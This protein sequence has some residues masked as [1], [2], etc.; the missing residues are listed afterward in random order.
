MKQLS[1]VII[2]LSCLSLTCAY[3][4]EG[5]PIGDH[6]VKNELQRV[7]E[8]RQD[9]G[10]ESEDCISNELKAQP[11]ANES[12]NAQSNESSSKDSQLRAQKKTKKAAPKND[13]GVLEWMFKKHKMQSLHFVDL[14]ELID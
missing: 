5:L 2:L 12:L 7:N 3:A 13:P 1:A 4:R 11:T 9:S 14:L 8:A 6:P 10:N